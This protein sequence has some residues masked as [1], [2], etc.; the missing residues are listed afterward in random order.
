M[1][2]NEIYIHLFSLKIRFHGKK[3]DEADGY[4]KLIGKKHGISWDLLAI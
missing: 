3:W 1:R 4:P 2:Y